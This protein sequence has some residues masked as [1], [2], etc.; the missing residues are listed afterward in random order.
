[1]NTAAFRLLSLVLAVTTSATSYNIALAG[2]L[3]DGIDN[4]FGK[5]TGAE[6]PEFLDPDEAFIVSAEVVSKDVINVRL[7]VADG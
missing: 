2:S 7:K 3:S 5:L 6:Q 4:I 1:M